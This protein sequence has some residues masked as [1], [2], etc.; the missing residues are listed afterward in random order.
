MSQEKIKQDSTNAVR[1]VVSLLFVFAISSPAV[2]AESE[3]VELLYVKYASLEE[4]LRHTPFKQPLVLE[5]SE[6]DS[7]LGG[8]IYAVVNHSFTV[9]HAGLNSPDHWCDIMILHINTKFCN[10]TEGPSSSRLRINLGKK[11]LEE[12]IDTEQL[13]FI[14]SVAAATPQYLGILLSAKQ[15]PMG[16][17]GYRIFLE[18]VPLSHAKTFLHLSFSYAVSFPGKLA[19]KTYLGTIASNKV[20]FSVNGKRNDGQPDYIGGVRGLMERNTMRY[21]LAIDAFLGATGTADSAQSEKRLQDWFTATERYPRQLREMDR[22]TYLD[23]K[24][25]EY[26]RQHA[27]N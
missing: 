19:M 12:L 11:T 13:E 8:D 27:A 5:S 1:R 17:S 3:R 6:S 4:S 10:A 2:A 9:V 24:R 22:Q 15:G 26:E 16:T 23:M 25:V 18:A 7:R 14:Y 21:Y 20:G